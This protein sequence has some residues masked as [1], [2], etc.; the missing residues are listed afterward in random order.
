MKK[1]ITAIFLV[2]FCCFAKAQNSNSSLIESPSVSSLDKKD[3]IPYKIVYSDNDGYLLMGQQ[4]GDFVL[5][6]VNN[7]LSVN[8]SVPYDSRTKEKELLRYSGCQVFNQQLCIFWLVANSVKNQFILYYQLVDPATGKSLSARTQLL[9]STAFD[10]AA[11][12]PMH[13]IDTEYSLYFRTAL[14]PDRRKLAVVFQNDPSGSG[15]SENESYSINVF[16]SLLHPLF[17]TDYSFGIKHDNYLLKDIQINNDGDVAFSGIETIDG[18][19]AFIPYGDFPFLRVVGMFH[20]TLIAD[21]GQLKNDKVI[22]LQSKLVTDVAFRMGNRNFQVMG[23]W[24]PVVE[25]SNKIKSDMDRYYCK[26]S[27]FQEYAYNSDTPL[28]TGDNTFDQQLILDCD[29]WTAS[30]KTDVNRRKVEVYCLTAQQVLKMGEDEYVLMSE[31][32][33]EY[34]ETTFYS[35]NI[36]ACRYRSN[37]EHLTTTHIPRYEILGYPKGIFIYQQDYVSF[38]KNGSI[39][40]IY[41]KNTQSVIYRLAEKH[42]EPSMQKDMP[43]SSVIIAE[44]DPQGTLTKKVLKDIPG[45]DFFKLIQSVSY[46]DTSRSKVILGATDFSHSWLMSY[47]YK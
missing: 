23:F 42:N 40:I 21:N 1:I 46:V 10:D 18:R 43:E 14:S 37:G 15:K 31:Q 17:K 33:T 36:I 19:R 34:T 38:V 27:F 8:E 28:S 5:Q 13:H 32:L 24:S 20:L 11:L 3:V 35:G 29:T 44:I 6:H 22:R 41:S 7:D 9:E 25:Y 26:G 12:A 16:D 30:T 2:V 4:H 45:E 39:F 47:T